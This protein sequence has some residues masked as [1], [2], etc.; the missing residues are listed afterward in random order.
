M[1]PFIIIVFGLLLMG[2]MTEEELDPIEV[3]V[4]YALG[5][6]SYRFLAWGE[7]TIQEE[8]FRE[9]GLSKK[10]FEQAKK[11]LIK[12]VKKKV[13][14]V[15]KYNLENKEVPNSEIILIK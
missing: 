11:D 2:C 6:N 8:W 12:T 4:T 5:D 15:K 7:I 14:R 9:L 13:K 3:E 10:S 1:K